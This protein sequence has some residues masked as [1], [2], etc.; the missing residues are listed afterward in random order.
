MKKVILSLAFCLSGLLAFANGNDPKTSPETAA[1]PATEPEIP[2]IMC[3]KCFNVM[4]CVIANDC[5]TALGDLL[6]VMKGLRCFE[7]ED[8]D[9]ETQ[10]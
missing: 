7:A 2:C 3:E 5:D 8:D 6:E 10:D 1:L 9:P 4:V